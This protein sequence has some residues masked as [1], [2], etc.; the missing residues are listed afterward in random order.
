MYIKMDYILAITGRARLQSAFYL[1]QKRL[2][3]LQNV[4][5]K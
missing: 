1:H 3:L 5:D 4:V 2:Q